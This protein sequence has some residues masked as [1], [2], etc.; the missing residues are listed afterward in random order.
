MSDFIRESCLIPGKFTIEGNINPTFFVWESQDQILSGWLLSS[1]SQSILLHLIGYSSCC[2]IWKKLRS[3]NASR[4]KVNFMQYKTEL[5]NLK[6]G[7]STVTEY[8]LKIKYFV[9]ALEYAGHTVSD[10]DHIYDI[11]AG[12]GSEYSPFI[13]SI[14][15][16]LY[17]YTLHDIISLLQIVE[18]THEN[19]LSQSENLVANFTSNKKPN[20]RF[21]FWFC[22][23]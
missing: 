13:M 4:T 8:V 10:I 1:I 19:T 22:K 21:S 9:D 5:H 11:P 2:G 14:Q 16:H 17:S 6:K 18:K 12:L 3:M 23:W 7:N 20:W 15:A